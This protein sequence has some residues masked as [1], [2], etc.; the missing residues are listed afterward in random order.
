MKQPYREPAVVHMGEAEELIRQ[1][2]IGDICDGP[3]CTGNWRYF[4][5][6][7][8]GK[9][10]RAEDIKPDHE[11]DASKPLVKPKAGA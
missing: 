6:A 10:L 11:H 4:T 5:D 7:E 2:L 8:K 9:G 3:P 1:N